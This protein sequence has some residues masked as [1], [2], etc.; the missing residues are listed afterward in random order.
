MKDGTKWC[1]PLWTF[2]PEEGWLHL[3]GDPEDAGPEKIYLR[4][5]ESC[6]TYGER[7]GVLRNS[8]GKIIGPRI[9]DVDELERARKYGWN[10]N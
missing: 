8:E 7:V 3:A 5:I 2:R 10:G 6:T 1:G 9:E 4:D